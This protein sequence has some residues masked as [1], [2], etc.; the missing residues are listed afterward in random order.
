[1]T[2]GF[3]S[4]SKIF[5]KLL[6]VSWE[7][8][9]LHGYDWIHCG[10]KSCTT[11]AYRWL[12][13]ESRPSVRTLW[14]AVIKSPNFLHEVRLYQHVFCTEP[15]WFF[16]LADL[17]ISVFREVRKNMW[18]VRCAVHT[19]GRCSRLLS[20]LNDLTTTFFFFKKSSPNFTLSFLMSE[21]PK[22]VS[23]FYGAAHFMS[24]EV[25]D[26]LD[27]MSSSCVNSTATMRYWMKRTTNATYGIDKEKLVQV[28]L[29]QIDG[30]D[31][32]YLSVLLGSLIG[33]SCV[34]FL[35]D[36]FSVIYQFILISFELLQAMDKRSGFPVVTCPSQC[37]S[38]QTSQFLSC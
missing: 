20:A 6:C 25:I 16:P 8:V 4:G 36:L 21:H 10:A 5:C 15:L 18:R 7:I 11:T 14:S 31:G 1:M 32:A 17:A 2:L 30:G 33:V 13:R 26:I 28:A 37:T 35:P 9:V 19:P 29:L 34:H 3:L 24:S 23:L 12:F 27:L 38:L 22:Q